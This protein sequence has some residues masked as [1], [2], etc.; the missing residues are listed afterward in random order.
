MTNYDLSIIGVRCPYCDFITPVPSA[1][2][3]YEW[4]ETSTSSGYEKW[5]CVKCGEQF[6]VKVK[7]HIYDAEVA[8]D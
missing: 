6:G 3:W 7:R 8:N 1:M 2:I 4:K 5:H